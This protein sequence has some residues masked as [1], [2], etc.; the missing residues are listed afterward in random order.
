M[1]ETTPKF[2]PHANYVWKPEDVFPL[3]GGELHAL[4][5]ILNALVEPV[6]AQRAIAAYEALKLIDNIIK[7][8]VEANIITEAP[9]SPKN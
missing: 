8:G 9:D 3:K 5:Q 4:K 1:S 7:E 2:N 6:E